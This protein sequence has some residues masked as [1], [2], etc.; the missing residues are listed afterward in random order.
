MVEINRLHNR[1]RMKKPQNPRNAKDYVLLWLKGMA[2]GAAD[3]VPGV[4]GGTVALIT[5][6]YD[7]LLSTIA[8]LRL[9]LFPK[10]F[11]EG[12]RVTWKEAN[13]SFVLALAF[14]IFTSIGL[15]SNLLHH[16][17]VHHKEALY[18]FFFGLVAASV[19]IVGKTF[20]RWSVRHLGLALLGT[21]I[22]AAITSLPILATSND[23]VFLA[24]CASI[25]AC[26]M[27][28]PG[29]SGS[30]ILLIL[31]AY[32][33]T[34]EALKNI[35]LLRIGAIAAGA[36][37]GLLSFSRLLQKLLSKARA[38]TLALLTGFLLGSL[39]ALWP[40]KKQSVLL[41]IHSDGRETW[42]Q[43]NA[44]PSAEHT[45]ILL[46]YACLAFLGA[47]IVIGMNRIGKTLSSQK[48]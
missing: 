13:V 31:G 47:A 11:R 18:A 45:E 26:A 16:L 19:P 4:S 27:I 37:F 43:T 7:E 8:S 35:D 2:M 25:A 17:L 46:N 38:L 22:A 9:S 36:L 10:L 30:F 41:H 12:L 29:I 23:P 40:W 5:G 39:Q 3:L 42:A 24:L 6:I 20:G 15:L 32:G 28:L 33:S 21:A 1:G 34:I 48:P 44:L 14:G